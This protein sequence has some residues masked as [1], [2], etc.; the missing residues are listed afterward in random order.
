MASRG[1]RM[2]I[3][4][5]GHAE[6]LIAATKESEVAIDKLTAS[7]E[8]L[9]VASAGSV[10]GFASYSTI[11][12]K[13]TKEVESHS[14]ATNALAGSIG[15]V[16]SQFTEAAK[17]AG[18]FVAAFAGYEALKGAIEYTDELVHQTKILTQATDLSAEAA[19]QWIE[20]AKQ[21]GVSTPQVVVAFKML[22]KQILA[23]E[24]GSKTAGKA[25]HAVGIPLRELQQLSTEE[26]LLKISDGFAKM[27]DGAHKTAL[28]AQF[29]GKS[30][31]ALLP[32]LNKGSE[33]IEE[34]LKQFQGLS[35]EQFKAGEEAIEMQRKISRAYDEIRLDVTFGLIAA[36]KATA[37]WVSAITHA[38]GTVGSFLHDVITGFKAVFG[39]DI[40]AV[41]D[42]AK[43]TLKGFFQFTSGIL[44]AIGD[45]VHGR[46]SKI[47]ED[48][49]AIFTGGVQAVEGVFKAMFEPL[50]RTAKVTDSALTAVFGN[51]WRSIKGIFE[52]GRNAVVGFVE[53]IAEVINLIPGVPD[54]HVGNVGKSGPE[55]GNLEGE[56][57][58]GSKGLHQQHRYAGGPINR[59]MYIAGEEAPQHPEWVIATNPAYRQNNLRYWAQAGHD[60]GVPGFALGGL[61]SPFESA[62]SAV[63]SA[64]SGAAGTVLDTA[65]AAIGVLPTPHLPGWLGNLGGYVI[66]QVSNWITSGFG[67]GSLGKASSGSLSGG[68]TA[69]AMQFARYMIQAGFP[70]S[71]KVIAEGLGTIKSESGFAVNNAQGPSGHIGPWAE[72]PAFGSVQTREDPLGSTIA[73]YRV[74]WS[75]TR[76]FWP[77][78]GRWEAEQSGLAGGGAASYGPEFM[79]VATSALKGFRRGGSPQVGSAQALPLS[80]QGNAVQ[81]LMQSVWPFAAPFYGAAGAHMPPANFDTNAWGGAFV[82]DTKV[83]D[84]NGRLVKNY[85][86]YPKWFEGWIG[87]SPN[88]V[89]ENLIHEWAHYF[90]RDNIGGGP[91]VVE[92]GAESFARWAAPQIYAKAGIKYQNPAFGPGEPYY[93]YVQQVIKEKGWPWIEHGQFKRRGGLV[94]FKEGGRVGTA[95]R[96]VAWAQRN[97]GTQQGSKKEIKW[98]RETGGVIDPWCAE[99]VGA[100]MKAMGLPL[101]ANPAYSGSYSEGW[102]GGDVVGSSLAAARVGDL[103]NFENE[104][105]GIYLGNGRMISGNWSNEVAEADVSED[106]HGL[107]AVIRPHYGGAVASSHTAATAKKEAKH[108]IGAGVAVEVPGLS[109]SPVTGAAAKLPAAFRSQL[110]APGITFSEKLGIGKEALSVAEESNDLTGEIAAASYILEIEERN[111]ARIKKKLHS[112]LMQLLRPQTPARRAKLIAEARSLRQQLGE[113]KSEIRGA[114]AT[115]REAHE[116]ETPAERAHESGWGGLINEEGHLFEPGELDH[117]E[118]PQLEAERERQREGQEKTTAE[119]LRSSE[120]TNELL[121]EQLAESQRTQ[122]VVEANGGSII[123]SLIAVING[124]I[125]GKVGLGLQTPSVAGSLASY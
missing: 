78:W 79:G 36:V 69:S 70:R 8:R 54:I 25:F 91:A 35:E 68:Q 103:L 119:L 39:P 59:P 76:S 23:A 100:D 110:A 56:G 51:T 40:S 29:F 123:S 113:A 58:T 44:K 104:H 122:A 60:L 18:A 7:T 73:A 2:A 90:Q 19:S 64:I 63:G 45:V 118:F 34:T 109:R 94:G 72:S 81:S 11:T 38:K 116:S 21:W 107:S 15:G 120:E 66:E 50:E 17:S 3:Y 80:K 53:D 13:A 85:L 108:A 31:T 115:Q 96:A 93:P 27:Q 125:G 1:G 61:A 88:I 89:K 52:T 28:N 74:G 9:N 112:V 57:R 75:P 37:G 84:K 121:R 98:A 102:S 48:A 30:A 46:F 32:V 49:K 10:K 101:P 117:F 99:F 124:G 4:I 33:G 111:R 92:G 6:P 42:D 43:S 24:Q 71:A 95:S 55:T 106:S 97:L 82:G 67:G 114:K 16:K 20:T 22:S 83:F 86:M 12:Q 5:E 105:I 14:M 87:K 41:F 47:W 65:K 26:V 62:A 77:A